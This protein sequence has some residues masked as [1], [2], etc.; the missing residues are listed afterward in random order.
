MQQDLSVKVFQA[1]DFGSNIGTDIPKFLQTVPGHS[2]GMVEGWT[3]PMCA[4]QI[5][6][7]SK[8]LW[9]PHIGTRRSFMIAMIELLVICCRRK[10]PGV[11]ASR[12]E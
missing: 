5:S 8:Q 1:T 11:L 2:I 7:P 6:T 4:M 10:A 12:Q 3:D 9:M